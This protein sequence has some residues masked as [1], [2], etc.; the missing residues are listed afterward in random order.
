LTLANM[1]FS[2]ILVRYSFQ[3]NH[4]L[5]TLF[6]GSCAS[7]V[8]LSEWLAA[9]QAL[10]IYPLGYLSEN[11]LTTEEGLL[12]YRFLGHLS[13]LRTM[14]RRQ[15]A[16]QIIVLDVPRDPLAM[17][18]IV[19]TCQ[20][21]GCRLLVYNALPVDIALPMV[22][23]TEAGHHFFSLQD[24]PLESPFN[25]LMKRAFDI[26]FTLPVVVF[27]LPPLMILVWLMQRSQSPGPVFF[28]QKR[29]GHRSVAFGMLKFRSM[30]LNPKRDESIQAVPNDA[31]IYPF[32]SFMRRIS[33]DEFPQ[34]WNVLRGE[35]SI[36]GPRPHLRYHDELFARQQ[37][38]YRTRFFV[39]PGIT[40]LAQ[41]RG[42]R[43][44]IT[45]PLSLERR[46]ASDLEYITRW[47]VWLD[48]QIVFMTAKQVIFP[49]KSAY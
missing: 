42:F 6:I 32:G 12:P 33:L 21:S 19:T 28:R 34:F 43:G 8:K 49:P 37:R 4:S 16:A 30:Y 24:E 20:E 15:L 36:V 31:R 41:S 7:L 45:D 27:I 14:I 17:Q 35:M 18:Q 44:E 1:I 2:R 40:G 10:G 38:K 29:M 23:V 13:Q 46:V 48:F 3:H 5:P 47:S 39:K 11:L 22:P 9:K 25:R 26:A